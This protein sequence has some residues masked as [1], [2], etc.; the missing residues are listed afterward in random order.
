VEETESS[1]RV[2]AVVGLREVAADVAQQE[3]EA[4]GT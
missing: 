2:E 3:L 4:A 1:L